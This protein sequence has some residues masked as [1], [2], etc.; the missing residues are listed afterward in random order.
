MLC[1]TQAFVKPVEEESMVHNVKCEFHIG[2]N[3]FL[4]S[5]TLACFPV[6]DRGEFKVMQYSVT[7]DNFFCTPA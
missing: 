7:G 2:G 3:H 1:Y 5:F 4:D 6:G